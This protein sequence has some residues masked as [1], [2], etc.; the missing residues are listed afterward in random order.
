MAS[1]G[2]EACHR[3][4]SQ[5]T[6][7]KKFDVFR[8]RASALPSW[9]SFLFPDRLGIARQKT[10]KGPFDGTLRLQMVRSQLGGFTMRKTLLA[11]GVAFVAL[12]VSSAYA[13]ETCRA[14]KAT[15]VASSVLRIVNPPSCERTI[16][17]RR[18]PSNGPFSVFCRAIPSRSGNRKLAQEGSALAR[19]RN[20]SNFLTSVP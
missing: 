7:V 18:V 2:I 9:A 16:C 6:L 15:P 3:R 20:T 14:T 10:E 5:G 19:K 1:H 13:A 11:T 8:L 12:Q 4:K 17:K